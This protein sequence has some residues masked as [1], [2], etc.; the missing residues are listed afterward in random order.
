MIRGAP[1]P[2]VVR[3]FVIIPSANKWMGGVQGLQIAIRLVLCMPAAVVA[4]RHDLLHGVVGAPNQRS[5]TV[6]ARFVFVNV[7]PDVQDEIEVVAEREI[8]ICGKIS[9]FKIRA[10]GEAEAQRTDG[11]ARLRSGAE[12][13]R[14]GDS[15]FE[16]ETVIVKSCRTQSADIHLE[17]VILFRPC[18]TFTTREQTT[19]PRIQRNLP[20]HRHFLAA[21]RARRCLR[22]RG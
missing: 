18:F 4:Q 21:A 3:Q 2:S 11:R 7:I 15:I 19:K 10:R 8:A 16:K 17:S 6:G 5:W 9:P 13:P 1:V 22:A 12:S 14:R 20:G